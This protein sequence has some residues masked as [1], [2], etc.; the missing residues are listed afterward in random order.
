MKQV[1]K[2]SNIENKNN[3]T[4]LKKSYLDALNDSTFQEL[5]SQLKISKDT[6]MKYTSSLED[7]SLEY[8]NCKNCPG[9]AA[10]K[11]KIDGYCYLPYT[12]DDNLYFE[13]KACRYKEEQ[14]EKIKYQ[15]NVFTNNIPE[16]IK[17]ARIKNIFKE[18]KKRYDAIKWITKF[19]K[20]YPNN[21]K[22][23]YLSGNFGSGKTYIIASMLNE[24]ATKGVKSSIIFWPEFLRDLKSSF[25]T[26][27]FGPKYDRIKSSNLLLIDDIGAE[28]TTSWSRDDIFCPLVQY[29]MENNLPTF[30]T[31]NLTLKEL[32]EHFSITKDSVDHVKAKRIISRIEQLTDQI[33]MISPNLRK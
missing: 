17:E 32:E 2:M 10:C 11:N 19:I 4:K 25:N 24:L 6:L 12:N 16:N 3:L 14:L 23:L 5:V 28:N 7:A 18:D 22:G 1:N 29:R 31:S 8:N 21:K 15:K 13:Y 27:E 26:A 33:E 9:L 20:E 30:F